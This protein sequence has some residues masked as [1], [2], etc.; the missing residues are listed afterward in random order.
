M[1]MLLLI[2]I[3]GMLILTG[4]D[5]KSVHVETQLHTSQTYY[6]LDVYGGNLFDGSKQMIL[7]GDFTDSNE[8]FVFYPLRNQ[9]VFQ[10]GDIVSVSSIKT[11]KYAFYQMGSGIVSDWFEYIGYRDGFYY[12]RTP[13]SIVVFNEQAKKLEALAYSLGEEAEGISL[14]SMSENIYALYEYRKGT[15]KTIFLTQKAIHKR[16]S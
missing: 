1:K 3:A 10:K 13:K 7:S 6:L 8:G 11:G 14:V 5:G 4:C 9:R 12:A 16:N 15:S 2:V